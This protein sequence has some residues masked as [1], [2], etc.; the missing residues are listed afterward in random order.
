MSFGEYGFVYNNEMFPRKTHELRL[1][2]KITGAVTFSPLPIVNTAA[3][4]FAGAQTQ[5]NIDDFLKT[6]AEFTA[7]Q[8]DSTSMGADM[9]GVLIKMNG[10]VSDETAGSYV[11]QCAS[12]QAVVATCYSGTGGSTQVIRSVI[13]SDT[14]TDSSAVTEIAVGDQGDIGLKINFGNTPDFDALTEG[15]I[16][17]RVF[18]T[19]V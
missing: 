17:V 2:W 18:W 8:F 16:E 11:G 3:Y 1:L 6:D 12:V 19:A 10:L 5:D 13:S 14:L 4:A 15:V 7:A 9:F